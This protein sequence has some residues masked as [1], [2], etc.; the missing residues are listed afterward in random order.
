MAQWPNPPLVVAVGAAVA[1]RLVAAGGSTARLLADVT[2]GAL[3][4]WGLDELV[5][6]V[7]PWRRLLGAVVL[8]VTVHSLATR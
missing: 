4:A 7:N 2:D 5:R 6:G 1:G 3:L 8:A